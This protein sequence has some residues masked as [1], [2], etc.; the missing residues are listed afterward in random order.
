MKLTLILII[1][2]ALASLQDDL[3]CREISGLGFCKEISYDVSSLYVPNER[4][5]D[6][7]ASEFY[8]KYSGTMKVNTGECL[9]AF[10]SY[11]CAS[12]FPKCPYCQTQNAFCRSGCVRYYAACGCGPGDTT[13]TCY[14]GDIYVDD[15]QV[16]T[17][18][19]QD[20]NLY[21]CVL[22]TGL[23]FC[24]STFVTQ[25]VYSVKNIQSASQ[26]WNNM[27]LVASRR[28][29]SFA[30]STSSLECKN[31]IKKMF[32]G[33]N[34]TPCLNGQHQDPRSYLKTICDEMADHCDERMVRKLCT[35][36]TPTPPD[37]SKCKPSNT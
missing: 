19:T 12:R 20:L 17:P 32:C 26:V 16:C 28:Y 29:Q 4:E 37:P 10:R 21:S 18:H 1:F 23:Q 33:I 3:R 36:D 24:N 2:F 13:L 7:E 31:V 6:K 5:M 8:S 9:E 22:P 30:S 11:T 15:E 25:P 35:F 14:T 27:D 34:F